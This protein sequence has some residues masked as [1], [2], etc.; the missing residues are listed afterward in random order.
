[1]TSAYETPSDYDGASV[2]V[3]P[4]AISDATT[5]IGNTATDIND[6]LTTIF[7]TLSGLELSWTGDSASVAQDFTS[8]WQSAADQLFGDG[9]ATDPGIMNT[10]IA[11]LTGAWQNYTQTEETVGLSFLTL[12]HGLAYDSSGSTA[13]G[14]PADDASNDSGP[15]APTPPYDSTSVDLTY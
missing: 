8:R 9:T 12:Y 7:S 3:D 10:L 11:G 6:Q 14:G 15:D 2:S 5:V 1:M 13:T 4:S